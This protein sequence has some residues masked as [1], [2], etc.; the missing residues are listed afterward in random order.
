MG[1]GNGG[2]RCGCGRGGWDEWTSTWT[3]RAW[4]SVTTEGGAM[5]GEI[6]DREPAA[7]R[8]GEREG[9]VVVVRSSPGRGCVWAR[10]IDGRRQKGRRASAGARD[11]RGTSGKGRE[12]VVRVRVR[13]SE[14]G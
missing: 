13:R 8:K 9:V 5:V 6:W 3:W 2:C 10:Q 14:K 11:G 4:R 1:E 7:Q 12:V